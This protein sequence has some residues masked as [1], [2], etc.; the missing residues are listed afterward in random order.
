MHF[1]NHISGKNSE[2]FTEIHLENLD[3]LRSFRGIV[4][5]R[6]SPFNTL[7]NVRFNAEFVLE[8]F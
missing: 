3:I 8:M 4:L 2:Y 6:Y 5:T 7:S 1:S